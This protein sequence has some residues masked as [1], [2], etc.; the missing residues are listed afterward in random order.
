MNFIAM[1]TYD[2]QST[3]VSNFMALPDVSGCVDETNPLLLDI[4]LLPIP[5]I[6]GAS[7]RTVPSPTW[8]WMFLNAA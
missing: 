2:Y 7:D 3:S 8:F 6:L 4:R 1:N 5:A